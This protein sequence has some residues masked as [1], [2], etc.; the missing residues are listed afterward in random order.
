MH[1]MPLAEYLAQYKC[2]INISCSFSDDDI[3]ELMEC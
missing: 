1:V 3:N 2:S